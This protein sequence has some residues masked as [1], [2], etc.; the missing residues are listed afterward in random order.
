MK[1]ASN[2][3][4]REIYMMLQHVYLCMCVCV[5]VCVR[6]LSGAIRAL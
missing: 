5:C 6:Y 4:F 1:Y 2:L 3:C